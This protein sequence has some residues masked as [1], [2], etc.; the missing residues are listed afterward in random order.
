M[1]IEPRDNIG[2]DTEN[3]VVWFAF[4]QRMISIF[5][6]N[7]LLVWTFGFLVQLSAH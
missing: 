5:I 2:Q 6:Q 4:E 7:Y 3:H 1:V